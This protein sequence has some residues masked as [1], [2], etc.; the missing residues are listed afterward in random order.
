MIVWDRGTWKPEEGAQACLAKGKLNFT[1]SGERL[2]GEFTLVRMK[3]EGKRKNWLMI[4]RTD[5]HAISK[6]VAEPVDEIMTSAVSGRTNQDLATAKTLRSDHKARASRAVAV[7]MHDL[8]E[9][10]G[11]RKG[12]LPP[13]VEPCLATSV[14]EPPRTGN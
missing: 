1:L 2:R 10:P 14:A 6:E 4:K 8:L 11:A 5:A 12:S 9:L 13:F 3:E 7:A